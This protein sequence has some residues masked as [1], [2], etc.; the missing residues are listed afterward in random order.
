MPLPGLRDKPVLGFGVVADDPDG[1]RC[2][3]A[4]TRL[5]PGVKGTV[6]TTPFA[7]PQGVP[8]DQV[9]SGS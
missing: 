4:E 3:H 7:V 8:P 1:T 2:G 6:R 9:D 5:P